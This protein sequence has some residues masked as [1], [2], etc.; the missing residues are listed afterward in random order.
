[1][2]KPLVVVALAAALAACSTSSSDNALNG[3]LTK[4]EKFGVAVGG[5]AAAAQAML[6]AEGYGYQGLARRADGDTVLRFQPVALDRK[7]AVLITVHDGRISAITWNLK[8][9][10]ALEG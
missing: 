10:P 9:V 2:A 1:M 4:G 6:W 3:T 8:I 7:G 5:D